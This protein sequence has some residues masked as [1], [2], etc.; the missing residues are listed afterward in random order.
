MQD[1]EYKDSVLIPSVSA[2]LAVEAGVSQGWTKW[3]GENGDS[4]CID[5][6]GSSAPANVL[7]EKYGFTVE[8]VVEHA[9][10]LIGK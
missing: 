10:K 1:K 3:T 9:L 2:R 6:F 7:F 8:K 5:T 4:I